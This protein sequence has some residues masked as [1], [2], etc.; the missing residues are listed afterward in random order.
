MQI[1]ENVLLAPYTTFKIG[2]LARFFCVVK[3]QFDALNAY[4]F[5]REK[6][7]EVFV[8]G[9]GSNVLISDKGFDGLV[10]KVENKGIE[11]V[12]EDAISITLK[13]A[14]GE[15]W[16]EVVKFAVTNNWWGVENLSHIPGSSGAIAVQNVGAYGQESSNLIKSVTVF[17]KHTHQILELNN[18]QCGFS[19]RKSIF[20]TTERGE[21]IIFYVTL[22]LSKSPSP[23]LSYRDLKNRFG[24]QE[25][26]IEA[27]RQAVIEIRDKKY[28]FPVKAKF[29]NA[30]SFLKNPV[31]NTVE[32]QNL[33]AHAE[34]AFSSDAVNALE[35]RAFEE[36]DHLKV[37]AAFLMEICGLKDL[38][39]G[40]AKINRNQPLVIIN[41]TGNASAKDVI[42]LA[43]TVI[44]TV[45]EKTGIK[46]IIEPE[47]VGFS[48]DD[49][50]A[51][52]S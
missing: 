15:A 34:R 40:G 7:L 5:A 44:K 3:D 8:L 25:P 42:K 17:N 14:S 38:E 46:L 50:D 31:L 36:N 30:G 41:K 43:N 2:G 32:F 45:F 6:N 47:L 21:Y 52:M 49:L 19:Y 4:E 20:N 51:I 12:N 23:I 11:I 13:I 26:A 10:A 22:K 27:I 39:E 35:T 48:K 1:Q 18:A 28:P 29:G 33:K 37:P 24:G 16:D 9:G